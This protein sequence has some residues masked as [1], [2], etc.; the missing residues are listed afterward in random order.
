MKRDLTVFKM[1]AGALLL[2][3]GAGALYGGSM[4][5]SDVSGRSMKWSTDMLRYSPFTN[6]FV[7]GLVLFVA[8][9]LLSI[10]VLV[11][12][13]YNAGKYSRLVIAQGIV[14]C[15][16]ILAQILFLRTVIYLHIIMG[17]TGIL[18]IITGAILLRITSRN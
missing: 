10:V 1:L 13:I 6:F 18:L 17:A 14:L 9:G 16:W 5:L 11:L 8:N 12:L 3:N 4:L 2:F 7:P 15:G